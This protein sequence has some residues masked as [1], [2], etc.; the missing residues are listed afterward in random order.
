MHPDT[1][2]DDRKVSRLNVATP[3][4][5]TMEFLDGLMDLLNS[6]DDIAETISSG[7]TSLLASFNYDSGLI[8]A[9]HTNINS[10]T[11]SSSI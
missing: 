8:Q 11:L 6:D 4:K 1:N 9:I 7:D 5:I 2:D 10:Q 3:S